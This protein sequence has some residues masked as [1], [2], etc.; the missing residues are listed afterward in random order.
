MKRKNQ[1]RTIMLYDV[2]VELS[3][4]NVT[5][6]RSNPTKTS[7]IK[8]IAGCKEYIDPK[9]IE[10]IIGGLDYFFEFSKKGMVG[11]P[12]IIDVVTENGD[13]MLYYT[14]VLSKS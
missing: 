5:M 13:A 8:E 14:K 2:F 12:P 10:S 4:N 7:T 11:P 1:Q 3:Y 9:I 6:F